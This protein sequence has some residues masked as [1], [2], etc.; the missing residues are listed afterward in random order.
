MFLLGS[1][2]SHAQTAAIEFVENRGQWE[3]NFLYKSSSGN[4]DIFVEKDGFTYVLGKSD[5]E[6]L[7]E[8]YHHGQIK[9][10]PVLK[11]HAYKMVLENANLSA[12]IEGGKKQNYYYNYFLG[13]DP[14][15]WQSGI[16]PFL[17]LDY[18]GIYAGVDL[19]LSSEKG[20]LKYDFMVQPNANANNIQFRFDGVDNVQLKNKNLVVTTS[21]GEV[22]EMKPLALQY[23]HDGKKEI[24]C[25]YVLSGN[26]VHF[27]FPKGYDK[28]KLLIID[29]VVVF[30]TFTGSTSDNWGFTATY[31]NQ[32]NFYAGGLVSGGG[33]PLSLGAFQT[34]FGGGSSVTG[35][36]YPCDMSITKFNAN[37]N[38]LA[39][40]TYIGGADNDQPHSMI[41]D[42][43]DNLIIAGRTYSNNYPV[44]PGCYDNTY[45]GD[46]DIVIT[47][48][49]ATGTA[50]LASTYVGGSGADVV[51]YNANETIF[52]NLK[53]NYGDDARSE[54]MI[55]NA[56]NIYMTA[57]TRSTNFPTTA[58][59][60]KSTL[61][62]ADLQDAIVLKMN[63]TLS[64][65]VWSTYLGGNSDDAGYVLAL[66]YS[67]GNL[68]VAGGTSST[69]FPMA[70]SGIWAGYQGGTADGFVLKFQNSFPY[71]LLNGSFIGKNGY[72]QVYGIQIDGS[73][74][75]YLMGQ[76]LGGTFPVTAGVYSNPNSSQFVIKTNNTLS[77]NLLSTVFGSGNSTVTNISPVAFLVDTCQNVYISGWGG[78]LG[79]S[80]SNVG[81]TL[82]L[83]LSSFPNTPAQSTTD[84]NDF[85]FIVFTPNLAGLLY[86][87]YYGRNS[88]DASKGEHV[89]GGTSRFDKNGIVYQAICGGCAGSG[90][91]ATPFPTTVGSWSQTNGST[92]CNLVALKIAFQFVSPVATA[93]AG[94]D[95]SGCPPLVVNFTNN[96]TNSV[97]YLW[98]FG[99]GSP[100]T[101]TASPT[102]TY[103][104]TGTF[105]VTLIANNPNSCFQNS[106]TMHFTINVNTNGIN[107]NFN[108]IVTDSCN[109]YKATFSNT[110][111][112][113]STPG[114]ST[115]TKFVW[116]F[117]D[118]STF[119][120]LNQG[121]H[122]FPDTGC[123]TVRLFMYDSTA[124]QPIDTATKV[125]C[126]KGFKTK[127]AFNSPDSLCIGSGALLAN[128]SQFALSTNWFLGDG[129][130]S[131]STSPFYTFNN[132]GTYTITLVVSNPGSCNKFDSVKRTIKILPAPTADFSFLPLVPV[133]N[134][135]TTFTNLSTNAVSYF[136]AFGDGTSSTEE[137]PVHMYNKTGKYTVC[138][139]A[140]NTSGCVDTVCK[141]VSADVMPAIGVPTA[142]SPNGD[143][144][145]DIL[146]VRGA[147]VK[148]VDFKVYNRFG[149]MVFE[150]TN[151]DFGWDGNY[152]G[153]PQEM[154]AY[155]WTL[156]A[157]FIDDSFVKQKG[158]VTLLR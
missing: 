107:A 22:L 53:H 4:R 68:Y 32:G 14:T 151:M 31:D 60:I 127:A 153:K 99:D 28:S 15:H 39:F 87:T 132:V 139:E 50:L 90:G 128:A 82:N 10:P 121:S 94:P 44:T 2:I 150:T 70:G 144:A 104:T 69:N 19:H 48:L 119:N 61:L 95:T 120:G 54:V 40:S 71:S 55:D 91:V 142:F 34:T 114:A 138:L 118:G 1:L 35:S 135:S 123:Y 64:N 59:A 43:N 125:V 52:G 133:T 92:N 102:H 134:G 77:A 131:T 110:S 58:T 20:N 41:V 122:S 126:L 130:T 108:Y 89:D 30:C 86:A 8:A 26:T 27:S 155:A 12:S 42:A 78:G 157:T 74:N 98:N 83:P 56:G 156:E 45:N 5:N 149:E 100:T 36:L 146:Y 24:P 47:K 62:G 16:H 75:V 13:K 103:T 140:K 148:T 33:Y 6:D 11:Y 154:E 67:Q 137:N 88:S 7:A 111:Q 97:N 63:G 116:D 129:N 29:P 66:D 85:Y 9:M 124:C 145:N 152:K 158:N 113:G 51:N 3:G 117:G 84:G 93:I 147:A 80:P 76:T 57:S 105:T 23:G 115:F 79:F 112:F 141:T 72:D 136:W 38:A 17:A 81:N 73:N 106:D 18:S 46:A 21:V 143:G 96:S 65:L 25:D 101:T 49:N 37:G 109:P